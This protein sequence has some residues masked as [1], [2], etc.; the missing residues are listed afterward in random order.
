M[1]KIQTKHPIFMHIHPLYLLVE[2]ALKR[3][4]DGSASEEEHNNTAITCLLFSCRVCQKVVFFPAAE[5]IPLA[6]HKDVIVRRAS[7][8][9][10]CMP[11]AQSVKMQKG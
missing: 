5:S 4:A 11:S 7:A 3:L 1:W 10:N 2:T 6:R 9:D 8:S